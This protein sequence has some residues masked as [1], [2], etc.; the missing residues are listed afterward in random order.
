MF[1]ETVDPE[2]RQMFVCVRGFP[3]RAPRAL[4]NCSE[5]RGF[6]GGTRRASQIS[7]VALLRS[8]VASTLLVV[9]LLSMSAGSAFAGPVRH[10]AC[11]A[12]EHDCAKVPVLTNRCCG[13]HGD[14]SNPPATTT[15]RDDA[16]GAG[17]AGIGQVASVHPSITFASDRL[18]VSPVDASPPLNHP[19]DLPVL[20][21][22]LRL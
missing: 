15:E 18:N 3:E 11:A 4:T 1:R 2:N 19:L 13:D 5:I 14:V 17:P 7:I 22:D 6:S 12:R 21:S 8:K 16:M 20:F 10:V 9:S